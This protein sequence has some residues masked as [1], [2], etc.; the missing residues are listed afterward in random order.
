MRSRQL[1]TIAAAGAI[2]IGLLIAN[3]RAG[4]AS[5]LEADRAEADLFQVRDQLLRYELEN[6][7]LPSSLDFLV[8]AYLR[9]DQIAAG[10]EL[11]YIYDSAKRV[12]RQVEGPVVGGIFKRRRNPGAAHLPIPQRDSGL[13]PRTEKVRA[14]EL[15]PPVGQKLPRPLDGAFVFEAEHFTEMNYGWETRPDSLC[16]GGAFIH[17]KEGM[18]NGDGQEIY[19]VRDFYNVRSSD[20]L[21]VLRYHFRIPEP[22][23]YYV[24][25]RLWTTGTECSNFLRV[26]VN[27]GGPGIGGMGNRVP[28]RWH[29]SHMN[30]NPVRLDEGDHY[31]HVFMHEDGVRIDQ[32]LLSPVNIPKSERGDEKYQGNL[33][34]GKGTEWELR[35]G[36]AV[37]LSFDFKSLVIA[38][39]FPPE[40]RVVLRKLRQPEG[41][42]RLRVVLHGAG[43]GGE[44]LQLMNRDVDLRKLPEVSFA[45]LDFSQLA[46]DDL[47]RREYLLKAELLSGTR[48]ISTSKIPLMRPFDWEVSPQLD[49]LSN[50]DAGSL[51]GSA[52]LS[53]EKEWRQFR[54]SSWDHLG[55][56][57]FGLQTIGN[58]LNAPQFTTIY[59][60]TR[61]NVPTSGNYL[62]KVQADD[63]MLLW[64]DGALIYRH[65]HTRPVTR[66][67]YKHNVSL[68]AGEHKIRIRVNQ[69]E[70]RWQ[71]SL[72]IRT[73]DDDLSD[74]TGLPMVD[75]R[76]EGSLRAVGQ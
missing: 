39:E 74:V 75:S 58:S 9:D 49:Y 69:E 59:A 65:D 60:R 29:W 48:T 40:C 28:F 70:G 20:D 33:I 26:A 21:T 5:R 6:G 54:L 73:A 25:G 1:R 32:F 8:P 18:G 71:A 24:Y 41:T 38:P 52:D 64:I 68:T 76:A 46:L 67:G 47:L 72:R 30:G 4:R 66:A 3:H 12:L 51:D 56:L 19:N 63:Q 42:A 27:R 36:P 7:S 31:L 16:G 62:L 23:T 13:Q 45:D 37:Q 11:L 57:D 43:A 2:L 10:G 35:P 61:V 15:R 34:P 44:D 22:G 17:C 55:V 14:A 50:D 53:P